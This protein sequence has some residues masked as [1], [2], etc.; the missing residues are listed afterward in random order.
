MVRKCP[1]YP[2]QARRRIGDRLDITGARRGLD[3][4]EAILTLRALISSGDYPDVLVMPTARAGPAGGHG[5]RGPRG[6]DNFRDF[7]KGEQRVAGGIASGRDASGCHAGQ[8]L[9]LQLHVGVCW[10]SQILQPSECLSGGTG[11]GV[12]IEVLRAVLAAAVVGCVGGPVSGG[13][14]LPGDGDA[15]V[16]A[17]ES[18]Q[19][20]CGEFGCEAEQRGRTCRAG[21][22][23]ELAQALGEAVCADRL[24]GLPAGEQPAGVSLVS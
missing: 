2:G 9:L 14:S 4:A 5:L 21:V 13:G 7:E 8:G 16:D 11:F 6:R 12:V 20:G 17:E 15:D 3:G 1:K 10:R 23:P 19:Q 18:C 22:E 24:A